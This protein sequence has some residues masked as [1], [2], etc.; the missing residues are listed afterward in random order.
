MFLKV[1]KCKQMISFL[2]MSQ[3]QECGQGSLCYLRM[4]IFQKRA[5]TETSTTNW[6]RIKIQF[7]LFP[8]Y[9][10]RIQKQCFH[11]LSIRCPSVNQSYEIVWSFLLFTMFIN[12]ASMC[13]IDGNFFFAF[14]QICCPR[15][16]ECLR[17]VS[18][19][20]PASP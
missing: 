2:T 18:F 13:V 4:R 9:M 14:L 19:I 12:T 7:G 10:M 15:R 8:I 17:I 20:P 11:P 6:T 3:V 16:S 1:N 5:V